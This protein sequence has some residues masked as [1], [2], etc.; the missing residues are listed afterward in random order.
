MLL[1]C[2]VCKCHLGML[3]TV[4]LGQAANVGHGPVDG[5]FF[6]GHHRG[7]SHSQP[8]KYCRPS[9]RQAFPDGN[10]FHV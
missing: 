4:P 9:C 3:R 8:E 10:L 1:G 7:L 5:L 6:D 2:S